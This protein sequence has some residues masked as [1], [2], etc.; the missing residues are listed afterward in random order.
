MYTR[1]AFVAIQTEEA[2]AIRTALARR[3]GDAA[4]EDAEVIVA[5]G[6]DGF[7]LRTLHRH[8]AHALPVYGMKLGTIGF[9]MNQ[10]SDVDLEQRLA[11]AQPNVLRPLLMEAVTDRVRGRLLVFFPGEREGSNYRLLDARDGWNYLAVPITIP[12]ESR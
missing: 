2:Q 8:R 7:M 6:G 3:H 1:I 4:I 10:Y 5:L 11:R 9:L 12:E